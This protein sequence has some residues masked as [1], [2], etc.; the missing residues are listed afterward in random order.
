MRWVGSTGGI[1]ESF[2]ATELGCS[3]A[4]NL[5]HIPHV[6]GTQHARESR[7]SK[8]VNFDR[9]LSRTVAGVGAMGADGG[10]IKNRILKGVL[11]DFVSSF[12]WTDDDEA[13]HF[14]R[15]ASYVLFSKV[16]PEAFSDPAT[17][18]N[19]DV[20][21]SGTFGIDSVGVFVND[22]LVT[23]KEDIAAQRKS[24]RLDVRFVFM[25]AK[26]S[27]SIDAGG[28]LK[29]VA[30]VA[31]IFKASPDVPLS[32]ELKEAKELIDYIFEPENARLFGQR[33]PNCD[34]YFVTAGDALTD[35]V[36]IGL[37]R[38][39]ESLLKRE[40]S[41]AGVVTF[42]H[43]G[44]DAVIEA[45]NEIENRF[46]VS[47]T[48]DR[49]V[50]CDEID[51]VVQAFIGYVPAAEFLRLIESSDGSLRR[52]VF[53][54]NV[55]DFQGF[56][57]TVN[58]EIA[59]T[60]Q[61]P[62]MLD[63][64]VL[65]NNGVTVVARDFRNVRS[66]EYEISDYFI[67]NGCQTSHMIFGCRDQV[68]ASHSLK[69]PVKIIHTNSNDLI[70]KIIR[71]TNR[72]SP[73]P[74]EAF[75]S[76]ERFHKRLQDYYREYSTDASNRIFYE[77]RSKEYAA[78]DGAVERPRI[79]NLHAQIRSF[80]S[81]MLG[82]PQLVMSRNPSTILKDH[83]SKLFVDGHRYGP[84]YC[85]AFLVYKFQALQS[86]GLIDSKLAFAKYWIAWIARMLAMMKLEAG[87]FNSP[88]FDEACEKLVDRIS[89][90]SRAKLLFD[91]A[92]EVFSN[93]LRGYQKVS[94]V[95]DYEAVRHRQFRDD[96]RLYVSKALADANAGKPENRDGGNPHKAG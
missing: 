86:K 21:R 6:A 73:V 63:K 69:I 12:G 76:L 45:Y 9:N 4:F 83:E 33:R 68:R 80:A 17:F 89:D 79:V 11:R 19:V 5:S 27:T 70:A 43:L 34:L 78:S 36:L 14:E 77:R 93:C 2:A 84:Y 8:C 47:I 87:P 32:E 65:L 72:Q 25:Q 18:D 56:D 51:G 35:E 95:R 64:F 46:Q 92:T 58:S 20:D 24:K 3:V 39:Q 22:S 85:A 75:V 23:S 53:Y 48:L 67:V 74:D 49:S 96:V 50:T 29:F 66:T 37:L 41:E 16:D 55:R 30:A 52:H 57:N 61:D 88:K 54:E 7:V 15:L 40:I 82:E 1:C 26:R 13:K 10:I 90:E 71:S 38:Q 28:I 81:V 60:L 94:R 44:A 59:T 31:N 42:K 62:S 91:A